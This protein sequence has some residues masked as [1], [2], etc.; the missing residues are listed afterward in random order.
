MTDKEKFERAQEH[1][2]ELEAELESKT[3]RLEEI[4]SIAAPDAEEQ[5]R[6]FER[7]LDRFETLLAGI[8]E[9]LK[10]KQEAA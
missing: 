1:I 4:A 6:E 5:Q 8:L 10:I 7:R 9:H 3:N 2:D